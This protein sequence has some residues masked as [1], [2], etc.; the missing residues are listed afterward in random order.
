MV[1]VHFLVQE[2]N[3]C[4]TTVNRKASNAEAA[5][6]AEGVGLASF[7]PIEMV[8]NFKKSVMI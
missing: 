7:F 4:F 2:Y 5:D 1:R 8:A 6:G 3:I